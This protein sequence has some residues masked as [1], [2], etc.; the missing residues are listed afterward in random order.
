LVLLNLRQDTGEILVTR[1]QLAERIGCAPK[2]VSTIMGTLEK[3]A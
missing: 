2:N 3:W 1:D